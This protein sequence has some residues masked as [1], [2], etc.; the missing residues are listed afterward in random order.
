[1]AHS[2]GLGEQPA[3]GNSDRGAARGQ[4]L[5]DEPKI[6]TG[7]AW[8]IVAGAFFAFGVF[9]ALAA[10]GGEQS[11]DAPAVFCFSVAALFGWIGFAVRL[12]GVIERRLIAIEKATRRP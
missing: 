11:A 7:L 9:A 4:D 3:G 2:R 1:M 12:F 5:G 10:A 8:F 6:G